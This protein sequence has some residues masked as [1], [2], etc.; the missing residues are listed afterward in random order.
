MKMK[1]DTYA[2]TQQLRNYPTDLLTYTHKNACTGDTY[3][4]S[5]CNDKRL[6]K[7][8]HQ[9]GTGQITST[10]TEYTQPLKLRKLLIFFLEIDMK[11]PLTLNLLF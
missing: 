3:S 2:L 8:I 11:S 4:C 1:K 6:E 7:N 5:V 9:W 10:L